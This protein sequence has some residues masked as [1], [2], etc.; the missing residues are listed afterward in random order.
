M[1]IED[2]LESIAASLAILAGRAPA[3]PET[4]REQPDAE[5][6]DPEAEKKASQA[7]KRKE[8]AAKKKAKEDA[9]AA[10]AG[11]DDDD[12]PAASEA[13]DPC[14]REDLRDKL[15][16][17]TEELGRPVV[18]ALFQRLGVANLKGLDESDY[19]KAWA[20]GDRALKEGAEVVTG[21]GND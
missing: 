4:E 3:A 21:G 10:A 1:N 2:S 7:K 18:V 17:V 15:T 5:T 19:A 11:G 14:T 9:E 8:T 16:T 6:P 20:L 12:A 13:P